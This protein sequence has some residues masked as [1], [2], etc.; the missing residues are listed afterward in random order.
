MEGISSLLSLSVH[1]DQLTSEGL[2]SLR[3]LTALQS[4]N[5]QWCKNVTDLEHLSGLTSLTSLD[6]GFCGGLSDV[7]VQPLTHM[8]SLQTLGL[9]SGRFSDA[10]LGSIAGLSSLQKLTLSSCANLTC[11]GLRQSLHILTAL[12]YL[13]LNSCAVTTL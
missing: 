11:A 3:S 5:L 12:K 13:D 8:A 6:L 1:G 9:S 10:G 7:G 2:R 4:L